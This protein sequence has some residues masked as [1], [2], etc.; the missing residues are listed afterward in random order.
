MLYDI[1]V[2][3]PETRSIYN[4][5]KVKFHGLIICGLTDFETQ[6]DRAIVIYNHDDDKVIVRNDSNIE[7]ID[8][9]KENSP[10]YTF[11]ELYPK[12]LW[13]ANKTLDDKGWTETG[14]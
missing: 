13:K 10:V 14:D 3:G 11:R 5:D 4:S 8:F 9:G 6:F 7:K 2:F 12:I 1:D